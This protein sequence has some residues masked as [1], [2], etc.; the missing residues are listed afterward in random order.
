MGFLDKAKQMKDQAQ[1]KL[2]ETQKQFNEGQ[3]SKAGGAPT[4][5]PATDPTAAQGVGQ[6][7]PPTAAEPIEDQPSAP[8]TEPPP[9]KDGVNASPDPFK[10]IQ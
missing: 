10:P 1:Q 4:G 6:P 5:S 7:Q 8:A 9:V 3:A 2:E